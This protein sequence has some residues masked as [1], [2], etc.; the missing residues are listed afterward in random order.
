MTAKAFFKRLKKVFNKSVTRIF[1]AMSQLKKLVKINLLCRQMRL[2]KLYSLKGNQLMGKSNIILVQIKQLILNS[3][4]FKNSLSKKDSHFS[5]ISK[6][7]MHLKSKNSKF[8]NTNSKNKDSSYRFQ[9]LGYLQTKLF[10]KLTQIRCFKSK[11]ISKMVNKN[12]PLKS[13]RKSISH[14]Q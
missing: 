9:E 1:L 2:N 11:V 8:Q 5:Q 3:N 14:L 10:Q 7:K 13:C 12:N 4:F 6:K